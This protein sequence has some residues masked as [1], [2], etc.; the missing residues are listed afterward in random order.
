MKKNTIFL[1]GA[2][3]G[4]H[5]VPVFALARDLSTNSNCRVVVIGVGSAIEKKFYQ[6]LSNIDYKTITAGKFQF[7]SVWSNF[8]AILKSGVGF[9]QSIG[10]MIKY[11]PRVVFLK[12]NYSTVPVAYAA[13]IFGV[14]IIAHESDAIIG[15]SNKLIA[16]FAKKLFVSYPVETFSGSGKKLEYSGPILRKEYSERIPPYQNKEEILPKIL[17]LGGSQGAHAINEIIF[18]TIKELASSYEVVHQTG[19]ADFETA[20]SKKKELSQETINNYQPT[21]F[22]DNDFLAISSSDLIISR[23]SSSIFEFAAFAKPVI[24][25][26]YPH[27]SLDHQAANAKYFSRHNAAIVLVE[28][29]L[30]PTI[31][32]S[33]ISKILSSDKK[34]RELGDNL[35]KVVR[36]GGEKVVRNEI[37]KYMRK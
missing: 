21:P 1:V 24:L 30:S 14:P 16:S 8:V 3:T 25:I 34:K 35:K 5:V 7:K 13:R 11:R 37:S 22:V 6:N 31:L 10:L 15:K 9:F 19:A 2:D 28:K 18:A 26:P 4:G 23:A 32:Y 12:G 36:F 17:I 20:L 29:D 33:A 27:A